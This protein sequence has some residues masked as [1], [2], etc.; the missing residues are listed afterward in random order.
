[1]KKVFTIAA[2]LFVTGALEAQTKTETAKVE[3]HHRGMYSHKGGMQHLNLN[4]DQ[5]K[6]L[7]DVK[8]SVTERTINFHKTHSG[9]VDASKKESKKRKKWVLKYN[10]YQQDKS[11]LNQ[12]KPQADIYASRRI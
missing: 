8:T 10:L 7:K 1:M 12:I 4:D 11:L 2:I 5:K 6:Q 9:L 3:K